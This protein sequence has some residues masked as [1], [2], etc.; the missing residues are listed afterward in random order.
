MEKKQ[1]LKLLIQR[2]TNTDTNGQLIATDLVNW[3]AATLSSQ[4]NL[5]ASEYR[6]ST[7]NLP[8]TF[9]EIEVP[10]VRTAFE[11]KFDKAVHV[12]ASQAQRVLSMETL[13][14]TVGEIKES[15]VQLLPKE[16]GFDGWDFRIDGA[17]YQRSK[18]KDWY[19]LGVGDEIEVS[20]NN[21]NFAHGCRVTCTVQKVIARHNSFHQDFRDRQQL[22]RIEKDFV[23]MAGH[24]VIYAEYVDTV[25]GD[26]HQNAKFLFRGLPLNMLAEVTDY[27]SDILLPLMPNS[28]HRLFLSPYKTKKTQ[29]DSY[30]LNVR[31]LKELSSKGERKQSF[32]DVGATELVG[33]IYEITAPDKQNMLFARSLVGSVYCYDGC[34]RRKKNGMLWY[35]MNKFGPLIRDY[36]PLGFPA[37]FTLLSEQSGKKESTFMTEQVDKKGTCLKLRGLLP[38]LQGRM[39]S[40]QEA[41][42]AIDSVKAPTKPSKKKKKKAAIPDSASFAISR[43]WRLSERLLMTPYQLKDGE[44]LFTAPTYAGHADRNAVPSVLMEYAR[45]KLFSTELKVPAEV[46][47][48]GA[49]VRI[50]VN[51]A[52][53]DEYQ[54]LQGCKGQ[55]ESLKV[56]S[57][58]LGHVLLT[59]TGGYPVGYTCSSL[60]EEDWFRSQLFQT[61]ELCISDVSGDRILVSR[62]SNFGLMVS[63]LRMGSFF[64][65]RRLQHDM[66][67][68]SWT[69]M[70]ETGLTC[71]ILTDLLEDGERIEEDDNLLL[72]DIDYER[73]QLVVIARPERIVHTTAHQIQARTLRQLSTNDWLCRMKDGGYAIMRT[74]PLDNLLLHHLQQLYGNELPVMVSSLP[75]ATDDGEATCCFDGK[76]CGADYSRMR[77]GESMP[78]QVPICDETPK[79]FYHDV[80][81]TAK[82]EEL[83]SG[84]MQWVIPTGQQ[85]AE[86]CFLC[87]RGEAKSEKWAEHR[88]QATRSTAAQQGIMA[89]VVKADS[90]NPKKQTLTLQV[91]SQIYKLQTE[92]QLH[93]STRDF[94]LEQV[95]LPGQQWQVK[96]IGDECQLNNDAPRRATEYTLMGKCRQDRRNDWV[97]RSA[98]GRIGVIEQLDDAQMGDIR[99]MVFSEYYHDCTLLEEGEQNLTGQQVSLV[100]DGY[101]ES[102]REYICHQTGCS[103]HFVIDSSLWNWTS[104]VMTLQ[105]DRSMVGAAFLARITS[106]DGGTGTADRRCL[107]PQCELVP[108][109]TVTEGLYQMKVCGHNSDGYLLEQN[110]VSALLTWKEAAMFYIDPTDNDIVEGYLPKK[111]LIAV[112]LHAQNGCSELR[113]EWRTLHMDT[114]NRWKENAAAKK[115]YR[116]PIHHLYHDHA[117]LA[118]DGSYIHLTA[119][120]IGLWEGQMLE[121]YYESGDMVED[122]VISWDA[123][124][125]SC[126]FSIEHYE[127]TPENLPKEHQVYEG[128]FL[129]YEDRTK[130]FD[131]FVEFGPNRCWVAKIMGNQLSWVPFSEDNPPY[132]EGDVVSIKVEI[133]Y[134]D[135]ELGKKVIRGSIRMTQPKPTFGPIVGQVELHRFVKV[136]RN[137]YTRLY[138]VD[139]NGLPAILEKDNAIEPLNNIVT[140]IENNNYLWLPVNGVYDGLMVY[141]NI[142]QKVV[143]NELVGLQN[144]ANE[145]KVVK[146]QVLEVRANRLLVSHGAVIGF[147]EKNEA[148]G[149]RLAPLKLFYSENQEI[150]CVIIKTE[151]TKATFEA[152]VVRY[153]GFLNMVGVK[154]NDRLQVTILDH[155]K[156]QAKVST[157]KHYIGF[158][159]REE[160]SDSD[161]NNW[162]D[163]FKGEKVWVTCTAIDPD[164]GILTFSRRRYL[165]E[166]LTDFEETEAIY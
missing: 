5:V 147:I 54:R 162:A 96:I 33:T 149:Q 118:L 25:E 104:P 116:A 3:G 163:R 97:V 38:G 86:G 140:K 40:D 46:W 76:V 18:D 69:M 4:T 95:F 7:K 87:R 109:G 53:A 67:A 21:F 155:N 71:R 45:E 121:N 114:L 1:T 42:D 133:V 36:L 51:T 148:T 119:S 13:V 19:P 30:C 81:L 64:P 105:R 35:D 82:A 49:S 160:V 57:I 77:N 122:C 135:K 27:P 131:C 24:A 138:L 84:P 128:R 44:L 61:I 16:E 62:P 41:R 127:D 90:S 75:A 22:I 14:V 52:L 108:G 123:E 125:E 79:V 164:L 166:G 115:K 137:D 103:K 6:Q 134:I 47:R 165:G 126:V 80:V 20:R 150:E 89:V 101:D 58:L 60:E 70:T 139:E 132:K 28:T 34:F 111:S 91:G 161:F 55:T 153:K 9:Q 94:L 112:G 23:S 31:K 117:F 99:Y 144:F 59:T 72:L 10:D 12:L 152:S 157:T 2:H 110:G 50:D 74:M 141:Y 93:L 92:E 120:Q 85:D 156:E 136:K 63:L 107:L 11:E 113:A 151:T 73:E 68:N 56:C 143:A 39:S 106:F 129:R 88:R 154:V 159:P 26:I 145:G 142:S 8:I 102:S 43:R 66:Q 146:V 83:M 29:Q 130:N 78:L 17:T 100:L 98:D 124:H 32:S 48:D 65:A 15:K 158:I 37:T